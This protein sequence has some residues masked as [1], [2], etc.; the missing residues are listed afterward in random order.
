MSQLV[1]G[2]ADVGAHRVPSQRLRVTPDFACHRSLHG[3]ANAIDDRAQIPRL[4]LSRTLKR[5]QGRLNGSAMCVSQNYDESCAETLHGELDATNLR[6][7]YD[8][9]GNA[10]YE[11]IA[12]PLIEDDFHGYP[13]IRASQNDRIGFLFRDALVALH[14]AHGFAEAPDARHEAS[15]P[16]AQALKCFRRVRHCSVDSVL[17]REAR[18]GRQAPP[19]FVLSLIRQVG[20]RMPRRG[21]SPDRAA[22]GRAPWGACCR[23]SRSA[24]GSRA[25]RSSTRRCRL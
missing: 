18:R 20:L 4:A 1:R 14:S 5:L 19:P 9:A 11:Q 25:A 24:A 15:V 13:R 16:L 10:D 21:G 8:V 2:S 17:F 6:R 22:P 7:G 3:R 23:T 12:Q